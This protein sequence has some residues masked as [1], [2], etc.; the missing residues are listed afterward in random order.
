M[1][2]EENSTSERKSGEVFLAQHICVDT[3]SYKVKVQTKLRHLH[4]IH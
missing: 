4:S 3:S 1:K 2:V